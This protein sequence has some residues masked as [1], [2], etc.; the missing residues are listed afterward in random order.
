MA[1]K[2]VVELQEEIR[3]LQYQK[4]KSAEEKKNYFD[5]EK[6]SSEDSGFVS[7][8]L[9]KMSFNLFDSVSNVYVY[10]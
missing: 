10:A 6:E 1:D 7:D 2:E 8:V 3:I 5:V 4:Q 9:R